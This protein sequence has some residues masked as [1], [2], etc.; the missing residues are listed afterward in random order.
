MRKQLNLI[1]F[2]RVIVPLFVM[3]LH[4]DAFM[5][6]YFGNGF[7]FL[8]NVQ[9]SGGVYYFFALSGFMMY[10]LY[11]KDF[12]NPRIISKFLY[13]RWIRIY[14]F[15]W[16]LTLSVLPFTSIL[17]GLGT[18]Q[19]KEMGTIITSLLLMPYEIEPILPPA[20]SL[21][22]TVF[23][24]LMF[25]LLFLTH[26][27]FS[28]ALLFV[29]G[30][31]S[32]LFGLQ[33]LSSSVFIVNFLFNFNNLIFLSGIICGYM[34]TQFR[35]PTSLSVLSVIFG[36][37]GFPLSWLNT[38]YGYVNIDLQYSTTFSSII[39]ILGFASIDLQ[40]EIKLPRLAHFLGNA[41]FS[42][43][44]TQFSC[45]SLISNLFGSSPIRELPNILLASILILSSII[46]GSMF[47]VLIEKPIHSALKKL[48]AK[49]QLM[50]SQLDPQVKG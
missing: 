3:L 8:L 33:I 10:Y 45:M 11:H 12:G 1:Q 6:N 26:R 18:G 38:Q 36:I 43:Y 5:V 21:V 22:Y 29:W 4:A 14:P 9:K 24:Y 13:G 37:L 30:F 19:N 32:L 28:K 23:Y 48:Q 20:W 46:I 41:S 25:S 7:P 17:L 2:S 39:L 49:R 40:K 15:Y 16:I 42:I 31:F 34:V 50:T 47:H 27:L 35:F 44:L